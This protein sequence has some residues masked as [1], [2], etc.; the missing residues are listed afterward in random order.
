MK[1]KLRTDDG[2]V[3]REVTVDRTARGNL[4]DTLAAAGIM[5][6]RRCGGTGSCGGCNVVIENGGFD[7]R[8][9]IPTAGPERHRNVLAC[10]I[11]PVGDNQAERIPSR[12]LLEVGGEIEAEFEIKRHG[13]VPSVRNL[14]V[15]VPPASLRDH[16]S[17]VERLIAVLSKGIG[18]PVLMPYAVAASMPG[19][20]H[21]AAVTATLAHAA[22]GWRIVELR[23][24]NVLPLIGV[25]IDVGTTTVA[26]LLVNIETGEILVRS[27]RYNQQIQIAD[28]V[29]S[30]ISGARTPTN[31]N[32]CKT[33][34]CG[35]RL[36]RSSIV[37]ATW[38]S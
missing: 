5:L 4:A 23:P 13:S 28:D 10:H 7:V 8:G 18:S 26:G 14:T 36:L 32:S 3:D 35:A 19:V 16:R 20:T 24:A 29:A 25:A 38:K 17:D 12:S 21:P 15:A 34:W 2:T 9:T 31:G 30:R 22:D 11:L 37:C 6:N 1:L 27:T 33:W